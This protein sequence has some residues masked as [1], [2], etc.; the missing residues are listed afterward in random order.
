M[1]GNGRQINPLALK[2]SSWIFIRVDGGYQEE[3]VRGPTLRETIH[4]RRGVLS[5]NRGIYPES[6]SVVYFHDWR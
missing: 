5:S 2:S 6:G 1:A 3:M 4:W